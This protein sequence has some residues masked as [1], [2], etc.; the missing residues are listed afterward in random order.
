MTSGAAAYRDYVPPQRDEPK[1]IIKR[2]NRVNL[3]FSDMEEARNHLYGILREI[4]KNPLSLL[5]NGNQFT[6]FLFVESQDL[7]ECLCFELVS[8]NSSLTSQF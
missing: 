1:L 3:T 6:S 8:R 2:G 5:Q 7:L 4:P